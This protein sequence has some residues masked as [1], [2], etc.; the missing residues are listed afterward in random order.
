MKTS[1]FGVGTLINIY[2]Q[3]HDKKVKYVML[4]DLIHPTKFEKT[5]KYQAIKEFIFEGNLIALTAL[6][7]YELISKII[8]IRFK[9]TIAAIN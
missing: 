4:K 1:K 9:R 6:N 2:Y 8:V 3:A 5:N 7:N